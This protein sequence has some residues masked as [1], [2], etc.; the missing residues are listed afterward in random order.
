MLFL[1]FFEIVRFSEAYFYGLLIGRVFGNC[2]IKN[3]ILSVKFCDSRILTAVFFPGVFRND[4]LF[5]FFEMNS[6]SAL[7]DSDGGQIQTLAFVKVG[8]GKSPV[9]HTVI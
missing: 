5:S 4:Q 8:Q 9:S 7:T 6:V 1:Y 2:G 3:I